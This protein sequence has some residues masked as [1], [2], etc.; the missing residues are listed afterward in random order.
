M[1]ND[2]SLDEL[3]YLSINREQNDVEMLSSMRLG[4]KHVRNHA[5]LFGA[6]V[7]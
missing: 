3:D 2:L 1:N 4:F 7:F 6:E 5:F